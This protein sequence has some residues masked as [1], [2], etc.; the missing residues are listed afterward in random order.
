MEEVGSFA[1]QI[2]AKLE[3]PAQLSVLRGKYLFGI[4]VNQSGEC[5]VETISV[6]DHIARWLK[7][8]FL[9]VFFNSIQITPLLCI[10]ALWCLRKS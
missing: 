6:F 2:C 9:G 8:Y 10:V 1:R 5:P 7:P 4:T 3:C